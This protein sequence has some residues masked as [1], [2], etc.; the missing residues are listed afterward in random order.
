YPAALSDPAVLGVA[1]QTPEGILWGRSNSG[2]LTVDLAAPGERI[3]ATA[4][5]SSYGMR[6]GTSAAAAFVTASLALLSAA[7]PDLP[8]STLREAIVGTTRRSDQL[9][10]LLGSGGSLDVGAAMHRVLGAAWSTAPAIGAPALR[11]RTM[12]KAR[13][14]SRV[15]VRWSASGADSVARWRVSLDGRVVR[16]NV[17]V[18]GARFSRR[19]ANAG[20]HRWR[21]VGFDAGGAKV[22][23]AE[24]AFRVLHRR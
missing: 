2:L 20:R 24:R 10:M 5:G 8:M 21:V 13:A 6:T 17:A 22:V 23:A 7:R 4:S 18:T 11:L 14:G 3:M 9:A 19:I 12:P 16:R 15:T 1:A